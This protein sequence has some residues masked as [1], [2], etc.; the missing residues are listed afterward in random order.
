MLNLSILYALYEV[1]RSVGGVVQRHRLD[2][3]T[4]EREICTLGSN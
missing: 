3:G 1:P 4:S 2:L